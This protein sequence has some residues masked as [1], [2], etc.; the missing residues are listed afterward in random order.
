M[1]VFHQLFTI[2]NYRDVA[3]RT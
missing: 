2:G 3:N 1:E